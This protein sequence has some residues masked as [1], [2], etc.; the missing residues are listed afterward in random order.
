M[1]A[2]CDDGANRSADAFLDSAR[3]YL[4]EGN[5]PAALIEASN[6]VQASPEDADARLLLGQIYADLAR[7]GDAEHQ[8]AR[9]RELGAPFD[10]LRPLLARAMLAQGR[11]DAV[12]QELPDPDVSGESLSA[13]LLLLRGDALLANGDVA[14]ARSAYEQSVAAAATAAGYAAL[15]RLAIVGNDLE[16]AVEHVRAGRA[17]DESNVALMA[18]SAEIAMRLGDSAAAVDGFRALVAATDGEA[19]ARYGLARALFAAERTEEAAEVLDAALTDAPGAMPLNRSRAVVAYELNDYEQALWRAEAA[20][21]SFPDDVPMLLIAGAS[22][23]AQDGAERA[24]HYATRALAQDPTDPTAQRLLAE[25]QVR[26]GE[27]DAAME[28]LQPGQADETAVQELLNRADGRALRGGSV[29]EITD[30]LRLAAQLNPADA[31]AWINLGLVQIA[32][33]DQ[34]A[35]V[36]TLER[37]HAQAPDTPA[38]HALLALALVLEGD[39]QRAI[40]EATALQKRFPDQP[41]GPIVLGAAH[42]MAGNRSTAE[43]ALRRALEL[44][45]GQPDAA[46]NLASLAA[47]AGDLDGARAYLE[48]ALEHHP[49]NVRT[50]VNLARL[51]SGAGNVEAAALA[52][53]RVLAIAPATTDVRVA[54]ARLLLEQGDPASALAALEPTLDRGSEDAELLEIAGLAY[55]ASGQPVEAIRVF[56]ALVRLQPQLA[57]SRALLAGAL[58]ADGHTATARLEFERAL[59]RDDSLVPARLAYARVLLANREIDAARAQLERLREL[60]PDDPRVLELDVNLLIARGRLNEAAERLR[61]AMTTQ[62][63]G[64]I[65]RALARVESLRGD[66]PA[67]IAVLRDWLAVDENDVQARLQL[68]EAL[69]A[70]GDH[71]TARPYYEQVVAQAPGSLVARNN[72]AWTL[73]ELG[74]YDEALVHAEA[75]H[76]ADPEH[77]LVKD[78]LGMI[79]LQTGAIDRA[80][81]LLREAASQSP[82]NPAIGLHHVRALAAQGRRDAAQEHLREILAAHPAFDERQDAEL[83][84]EQLEDSQSSA[85]E[86]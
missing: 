81:A 45:P 1:L 20:L 36:E 69:T 49:D 26:L 29:E 71:A 6:A 85:A 25:A 2:A 63:L 46:N 61:Q 16:A 35:A 82:D 74:V 12:L 13:E 65:S 33:G 44:A 19:T 80:E 55:M 64:P 77:P 9:A 11:F 58:L 47:E 38:A 59:D 5:G 60:A 42:L 34:S 23:L 37:A 56:E 40:E 79:L 7:W 14:A 73:A 28:T 24:H 57:R 53:E 15:G 22:S 72:L 18:L 78:T 8:L 48:Q 10:G 27:I 52:Y 83:L 30:R 51:E 86:R 68:A 76:A 66:A 43:V 4:E 62:P 70:T 3:A 84:L 17:L 67:A 31:Q 75:A 50:L 54:Y 21:D 39:A 32:A 41:A